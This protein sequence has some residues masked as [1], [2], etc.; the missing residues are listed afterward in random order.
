[1]SLTLVESGLA[2]GICRGVEYMS[3]SVMKWLGACWEVC[4]HQTSM[5]VFQRLWD[6]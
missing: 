4:A 2:V 3:S 6:S 1:M 5:L